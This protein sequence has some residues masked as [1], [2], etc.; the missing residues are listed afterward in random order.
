VRRRIVVALAAILVLGILVARRHEVVR[1][2][3]THAVAIAIGDDVTLVDQRIG[4]SHAALIGLHVT[5]R[6]EPVIDARRI[7]VWYSLRDMLPG[8]ARRFGLVG[9]AVDH[10]TFAIIKRADG[11]YNLPLPQTRSNLPSLPAAPNSVPLRFFVRVNDANGTLRLE[12]EVGAHERPLGIRDLGIRGTID[13]TGRSHYTVVGEFVE[14]ATEPFTITGTID[15]PRGYAVHRMQAR[16]FPVQ[17]LANFLIDSKNVEV[18]GGTATGFDARVFAIGTKPNGDFDYHA[19]LG[20]DMSGGSLK[21]IGLIHPV[22]NIRCRLGLYDETFFFQS[23]HATIVGIPLQAEGAIYDFSHAQIRVGVTGDADMGQLRKAF[24][25]S[26]HQPI[27]GPLSMGILVEGSLGDPIVVAHAT[28]PRVTYRGMPFDAMHAGIEYYH[29]LLALSPLHVRYGGIE[30]VGRGTLGLG[31]HI[32]ERMLLRFTTPANRLPYAGALLGSEPLIGDAAVDGTDLLLHV[33]GTMVA[34]RGVDRAASLFD[35]EPNG[36]ANVAPF[37]MASGRGELAGGYRLDRPDGT[38]AFWASASDLSMRGGTPARGVLPGVI[39]PE[40]PPISGDVRSVGIVGGGRTSAF[41]LAGTVAAGKTTIAAVPF[42]SL[43]ASFAGGISRAA[44][45]GIDATGPWGRFTGAGTFSSA[46][47]FARGRFDGSLDA[48]RPVLSGIDARGGVHG[49]IAIG[50]EPQGVLVQASGL[51]MD[52]A[53]VDGVPI[54]QADG[55]LVVGN[56]DVRVYA[57]H[58]RAAGGDVVVAGDYRFGARAPGGDTLAFVARDVNA[59]SLHALGLPL[60]AGNLAAAGAI[61]PGA[62]SP[63]FDGGISIADGRV[64]GYPFAG[65]AGVDFADGRAA[66]DHV[67]ASVAGIDGFANGS[68]GNI[69]SGAPTYDL[70][71]AIP[72]GDVASALRAMRIPTYEMAGTFDADLRIGGAGSLPS[73]SGLVGMPAGSVNGLPFLD[74]RAFIAAGSDG[75]SAQ[76]GSVLVGTTRAAF[77]AVAQR[78]DNALQL[79]A[80]TATLSDF[81]NFFDTGDTLAGKGSIALSLLSTGSRLTTAGDVDVRGFRFRSLPIGDTRAVWSSRRNLVSGSLAVGGSEGLLRARGAVV[82]SPQAQ[83]Q[84]TIERSRYHLSASVENLDL[85]LWVAAIGFPQ[86]PITGRAFGDATMIGTYPALRLQGSAQL[87]NGTL[88]RFPIDSFDIGFGSEGS[89]LD[90]EHAELQGPGVTAR[91][92]GSVGL[93][94]SDPIDLRVDASTDDLPAFLANLTKAPVPV[95]G[96]FQGSVHVGGTLTALVLDASFNA[97]NVHVVGVPIATLFGSVRLH[98]NRLEL[99]NAGATFTHGTATLA[100]DLPIRLH[101]FGLP[102]NTPVSFT[103]NATDVDASVFDALF[104]HHTMLG[105]LIGAHASIAG[106]VEDPRMSGSVTLAK[107]S[108]QSDYDRAPISAATGTL[109]FSGSSISLAHVTAN[110]G[111]GNVALS[112]RADVTGASGATF[113]GTMTAHGA[114]FNSPTYGTATIDG[115]FRLTRTTGNAML[116]GNTTIT[117]ATIPFAVFLGSNGNGGTAGAA[118]PLAF[119]LKMKAGANV[120]VRGSGYG[121]GLDIGGTGSAALGGTFAAPTL[122]GRFVSTGG[123]LTYFDRSFRVLQANVAFTPADGILPA[124]YAVATAN[125]VNPDPDIARNPFG[126]AD[127]TITVS[128]AV[129]DL[130]VDF[131]SDPPG[132]TRDQIIALLAPFGGFVSGIQF[133]PY[134]VQIPGGAAAVVNNAPVPGGVFVQRNGTLTVSQEAF[135]ILNAQFASALLAPVENVLGET[136]GVSDVNL[137]LGY[138]GN[139]GISVRRVLGK[140]VSAVYSSTF[141]L[142]NRQSFGIQIAPDMLD[143]ASLSFFYQTGQLRLFESPGTEFGP[144]LLGQPLEGQ[145]GFSFTFQHFF[146]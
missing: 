89:R 127:I 105:G 64:Q 37:W 138:F 17:S 92:S 112:G 128:G 19:S 114:Q 79:R 48:L 20:F 2:V 129:D 16:V 51:E 130:K 85:G 59:S 144:V 13:D 75:V 32:R 72:A 96:A 63:S 54:A 141:G 139:V 56:G 104:G 1:F 33:A 116:S 27:A 81:N 90:I 3:L 80:P 62:S 100:G 68:I 9:I 41:E 24:N 137:T 117:N 146:K 115:T 113:D 95:S 4:L 21:L 38:S 83:W 31:D 73:I 10:P 106:T 15:V 102:H 26:V 34:E 25:F 65:S 126:A 140:T 53:S 84:A 110:V 78:G 86:V 125:V 77:G 98:G 94:R 124:L 42:T 43:T 122:D 66:F 44:I 60:E 29:G 131:T 35:F 55:T 71:A 40:I 101:P 70:H 87:R 136:L 135:S 61:S 132:Y 69:G 18:L 46:T 5:Q 8:S 145:S 108:Y 14:R 57:A 67:V 22:E 88:G 82:L 6:G 121:A 111:A 119:D 7:D 28:S 143:A 49:D 76:D 120:R 133:N 45:T 12:D 109:S 93:R 74:G 142:P 39:L 36:T 118:W 30:T 134:Q 97:Q 107:G 23:L 50:L 11:S 47:I 91:A 123:T 103:V 99:H 58:V 52:G